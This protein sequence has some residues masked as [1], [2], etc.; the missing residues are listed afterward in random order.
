MAFQDSPEAKLGVA[1]FKAKC[2]LRHLP[3][4]SETISPDS[5]AGTTN[6]VVGCSKERVFIKG[7]SALRCKFLF[8]NHMTFGINTM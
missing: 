5:V 8:D 2:C 1:R 3:L 7:K 6:V 4:N